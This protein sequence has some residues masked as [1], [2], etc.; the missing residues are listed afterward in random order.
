MDNQ[1]LRKLLEQLHSELENTQSV[2]E[3]SQEILR[4]LGTDIRGLLERSES[5]QV[6][7]HPT[8]VKRLEETI[9]NFE[10]TYPALTTTI[11]KILDVL[12][13]AGI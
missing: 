7:L 10:V 3:Q 4:D 8:L 6:E 9:D 11:S 13:G 1:K 12:S 2:D 5:S